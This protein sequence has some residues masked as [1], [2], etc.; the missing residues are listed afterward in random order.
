MPR[1]PLTKD[2]KARMQSARKAT[3]QEREAAFA[4][5]ESN[6]QFAHPKFWAKVAPECQDDVVRAIRK[7][8]KGAKKAEIER[9]KAKVAELEAEM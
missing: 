4:A 3:A 2:Q 6:P 7:A 8:Q 9:L 1:K 5:L